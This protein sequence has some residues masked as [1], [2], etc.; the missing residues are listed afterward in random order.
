M[1]RGEDIG[2]VLSLIAGIIAAGLYDNIGIS[3]YPIGGRQSL[4]I[5]VDD[6]F[7]TE[8]VYV[9][10]LED[11]PMLMTLK[12]RIIWTSLSLLFVFMSKFT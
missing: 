4:F 8:V 11:E 12:G 5:R 3:T 10:I 2:N 1:R 7:P 9:N 6:H